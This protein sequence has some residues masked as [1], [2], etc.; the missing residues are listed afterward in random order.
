MKEHKK[1]LK[2]TINKS[3]QTEFKKKNK[4]NLSFRN[5]NRIT[6]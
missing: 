4:K 5:S 3:G 1:T 2:H 6:L